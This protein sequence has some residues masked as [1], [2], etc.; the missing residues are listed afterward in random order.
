MGVALVT[1]ESGNAP[2]A[3]VI[4]ELLLIFGTGTILG[5]IG[6]A[7]AIR[8]GYGL[9]GFVNLTLLGL[10]FTLAIDTVQR[11]RNTRRKRRLR[12]AV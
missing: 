12:E 1:R 11:F 7:E 8:Y 3:E 10:L 9:F 6:A 4:S 5:P 2:P